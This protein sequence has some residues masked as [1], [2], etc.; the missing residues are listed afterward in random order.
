MSDI[1]NIFIYIFTDSYYII[2]NKQTTDVNQ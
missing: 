2:Y 1:S